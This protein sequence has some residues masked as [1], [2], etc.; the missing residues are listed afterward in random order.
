MLRTRKASLW[1][2]AFMSLALLATACGGD[3]GGGGGGEEPTGEGE[4]GGSFVMSL[5]EPEGLI[6]TNTNETNGSQILQSLFS[7]LIEYDVETSEPYNVVAESIESDDDQTW[8]ITLKEGWTFH[9]GESVTAQS[10]VDAW[11]Y[12]AN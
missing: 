8:T 10:F 1:L 5:A 6:P 7:G 2:A 4:S 3:D 9:N 12:G 11:N